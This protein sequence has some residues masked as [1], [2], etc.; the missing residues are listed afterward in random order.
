MMNTLCGV[1]TTLQFHK[2]TWPRATAPRLEACQNCDRRRQATSVPTCQCLH[3]TDDLDGAAENATCVALRRV[4][5]GKGMILRVGDVGQAR[6]L[7]LD[8][9]D[10]VDAKSSGLTP[11]SSRAR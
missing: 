4:A 1:Q 9:S 6:S 11:S 8:E 2:P 5:V 10:A 3:W 7:N